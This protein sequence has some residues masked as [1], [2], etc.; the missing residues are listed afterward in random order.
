MSIIDLIHR[1]YDDITTPGIN[2]LTNPSSSAILPQG[3]KNEK[4]QKATSFRN[5]PILI[6]IK[7]LCQAPDALWVRTYGGVVYYYS[8][9]IQQASDGEYIISGITCS[10]YKGTY[11]YIYTL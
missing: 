11:T 2:H 9:S 1:Y 6:F 7:L 3:Q 8:S 4:S 5:S 10:F